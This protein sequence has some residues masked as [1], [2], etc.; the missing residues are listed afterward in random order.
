MLVMGNFWVLCSDELI[1]QGRRSGHSAV[2][3]AAS[4]QAFTFSDPHHEAVIKPNQ[5]WR[6]DVELSLHTQAF[7]SLDWGYD[8]K[9]KNNINVITKNGKYMAGDIF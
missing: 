5:S 8:P 3:C 2:N 6:N 9:N 1:L 7:S 4:P